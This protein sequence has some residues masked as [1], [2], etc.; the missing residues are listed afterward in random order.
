MMMMMKNDEK[1]CVFRRLIRK[2]RGKKSYNTLL[3]GYV[4][5]GEGRGEE[6]EKEK[7]KKKPARLKGEDRAKT[8]KDRGVEGNKG[9]PEDR[10]PYKQNT[11]KERRTKERGKETQGR[12]G[13]GRKEKRDRKRR[14]KKEDG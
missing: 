10:G 12:K 9:V 4:M 5:E 11:R 6:D 1:M 14:E 2:N 8:E 3:P 7:R 13:E